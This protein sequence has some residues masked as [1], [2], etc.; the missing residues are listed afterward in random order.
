MRVKVRP[1]RQ[2]LVGQLTVPGDKSLSHRAA[3]LGGLAEGETRISNFL[4]GRDCLATLRIL[5]QLGVGIDRLAPG[6]VVVKG[7][8]GRLAEPEEVLDAA[9]SGTTARLMLGVLAGQELGAVLTGDASLRRRPMGRVTGPLSRMGAKFLGRAGGDRLPLAVE[10]CRRLAASKFVLP[11]ASA[12][13]KSAL[14][15][16]GLQ[17]EGVTRVAE[18][19]ASRDHTERLLP[20]FGWPV[21]REAPTVVAVRGPAR[22]HGCRVAV[23][24]DLSSALFFAVA[25]TLVPGSCLRLAHV[26]LNPTRTGAL[27]VLRRMGAELELTDWREENGEPRGTL[28]VYSAALEATEVRPEE[29]PALI[30]EIP[31]LA[32]AAAQARGTTVFR[33]VGELRNKETDRLAALEQEL[34]RLGV[35]AQAEGDTLTVTGGR[36]RGGLGRSH[37]DHRI[38]MA[39]A[40]A[41]LASA[42]GVEVAG[43]E[44]VEVSFPGFFDLL[45]VAAPGSV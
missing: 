44:C 2:G 38:A 17:A 23:P 37:G 19:A 43:A 7:R 41:G 13:V 35:V 12:Q 10:G 4:P 1:A 30:D 28:V 5:R 16:A 29:V 32:V 14:L 3:I 39:L 42:E 9:N 27:G 31:V 8:A 18:P 11:V 22:L 40:V 15:L 20:S 21:E 26:G 45:G 36:L 24:G 25:A 34:R 6:E 33:G